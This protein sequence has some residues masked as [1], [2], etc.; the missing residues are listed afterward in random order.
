MTCL[1][2][3]RLLPNATK[4]GWSFGEM[5]GL[6]LQW[7]LQGSLGMGE[8]AMNPLERWPP[9]QRQQ[10]FAS[11]ALVLSAALGALHP[12]LGRMKS[13]LLAAQVTEVDILRSPLRDVLCPVLGSRTS[14]EVS[15]GLY[16]AAWDGQTWGFRHLCGAGTLSAL[17]RWPSVHRQHLLASAALRLAPAQRCQQAI[18]TKESSRW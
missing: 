2:L 9:V 18:C 1:P 12:F 15:E 4:A 6:P 5:T 17:L 13:P 10:L 11:A 8:L 14:A 7:F 16:D 3:L